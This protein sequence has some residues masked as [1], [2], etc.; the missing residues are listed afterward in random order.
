[1]AHF[2][3]LRQ[4]VGLLFGGWLSDHVGR[5]PVFMVGAVLMA[6][7]VWA[8][9]TLANLHSPGL[10][11]PGFAL[12]RLSHWPGCRTGPAVARHD[13][14]PAG[15]FRGRAVP[16]RNP[17]YRRLA[18]VSDRRRLR[19]RVRPR[20]RRDFAAGRWRAAAGPAA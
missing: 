8:M 13:V 12:A 3:H 11:I 4:V 20:Q 15:R 1:L 14:R 5:R 6:V 9:F 17:L 10:L 7:N 19:W 16:H 2:A 18:W